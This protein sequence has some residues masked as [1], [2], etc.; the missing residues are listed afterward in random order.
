MAGKANGKGGS[1]RGPR[2]RNPKDVGEPAAPA[3]SE[4]ARPIISQGKLRSLMAAAR[5]ATKDI[6]SVN[7]TIRERIGNAK[8]HDHLHTGVF[9]LIRKLDRMEPEDLAEYLQTMVVY[10]DSSGLNDRAAKVVRMEFGPGDDDEDGEPEGNV[11]A[12]PKQTA[13]AAE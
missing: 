8:E 5:S 2:A 11:R 10:L 1:R 12:F 9:S 7:G 4:T 6:A 13:V 3:P